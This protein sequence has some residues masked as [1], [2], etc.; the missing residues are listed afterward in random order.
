M[1]PSAPPS[2]ALAAR[3]EPLGSPARCVPK[4]TTIFAGDVGHGVLA[5]IA[6]KCQRLLRFG[7]EVFGRPQW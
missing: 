6:A 7:G 5:A 1:S 4:Q 3:T 2:R